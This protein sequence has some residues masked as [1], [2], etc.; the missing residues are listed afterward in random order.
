[1]RRGGRERREKER[2]REEGERQEQRELKLG[3]KVLTFV[4]SKVFQIMV[5]TARR[6]RR[7][8]WRC[9]EDLL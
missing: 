7:R 2:E 5:V 6:G 8:G 9:E 4:P 1:M 3:T